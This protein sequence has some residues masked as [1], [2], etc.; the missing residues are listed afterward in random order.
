MTRNE[1][2]V[3]QP[4]ATARARNT[5]SQARI[6]WRDGR[7]F[8]VIVLPDAPPP[9]ARSQRTRYRLRDV[10]K[11]GD[12]AKEQPFRGGSPALKRGGGMTLPRRGAS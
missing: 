7:L 10:G 11:A 1:D 5:E 9:P 4:G 6:E 2:Q 8:T 3:E 12:L